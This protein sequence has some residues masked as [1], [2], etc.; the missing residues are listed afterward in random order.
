MQHT[1]QRIC[2]LVILALVL[3]ACGRNPKKVDCPSLKIGVL[4]ASETT[5][6]GLEQKQGYELALREINK[7]GLAQGCPIE[8]IY[9]DEGESSNTETA[10]IA[11]LDMADEGVVAILGATSNDATIK[12]AAISQNLKIPLIIPSLAGDDVHEEDNQWVFRVSSSNKAEADVA[13]DMVKSKLGTDVNVAIFYENTAFGERSAVMTAEAVME[14]NMNV[15]MYQ[16]VDPSADDYNA[17]FEQAVKDQ[18][19]IIYMIASQSG[20]AKKMVASVENQTADSAQLIGSGPGFI[21]DGFLYDDQGALNQYIGNLVIATPWFKNL[22]RTGTNQFESNLNSYL[23]TET[24]G[25]QYTA[26]VGNV[27]TYVALHLVASAIETTLLD[28][29]NNWMVKL[30]KP[31]SFSNFREALSRAIRNNGKDTDTLL[32]SIGFDSSGNNNQQPVLI[33]GIDG[34]L[35]IVYPSQFAEK[36]P[37]FSQGW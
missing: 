21:D 17:L 15:E 13:F 18:A 3:T 37:V 31:D 25:K 9:K 33:Q 1:F 36:S 20:T 11:M 30:Q 27:E 2:S 19:D 12:A 7:K 23:Q 14:K 28:T 4:I 8:L 29:Q 5:N 10:Q 22:P 35:V 24:P 32:G 16:S 26:G 34:K 6:A